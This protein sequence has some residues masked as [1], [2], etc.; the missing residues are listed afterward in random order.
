M[1]WEMFQHGRIRHANSNAS[2]ASSKASKAANHSARVERE[3]KMLDGRVEVLALACQ[4][5]W[6]PLQEHT[7]VATADFDQKMEEI[8]LRDGV[9]DGRITKV[10]EAC[11]KCGR[12]TSR[13]RKNCLYCG[14]HTGAPEVFG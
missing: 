7:S 5:L 3:M 13:R 14:H 8:D 1:L 10:T 4:S 12:K 9:Q 11:E 2:Q 6:E